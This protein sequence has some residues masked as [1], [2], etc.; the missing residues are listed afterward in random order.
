MS[1]AFFGEI[2]AECNMRSAFWLLQLCDCVQSTA[3]SFRLEHSKNNIS[4]CPCRKSVFLWS[5]PAASYAGS[6]VANLSVI[7]LGWSLLDGSS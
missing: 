4:C 3:F 1:H 7:R 5:C 6:E 2:V